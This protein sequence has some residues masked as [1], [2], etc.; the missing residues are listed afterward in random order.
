MVF[1]R[2]GID[3]FAH[4]RRAA[5]DQNVANQAASQRQDIP[6]V[7]GDYFHNG[8]EVLEEVETWH[9]HLR[10]CLRK[11]DPIT[12]VVLSLVE[13]HMLLTDPQTRISAK[14]LCDKLKKIKGDIET[15]KQIPVPQCVEHALQRT[16]EDWAEQ[17]IATATAEKSRDISLSRPSK[18]LYHGHLVPQGQSTQR[19]SSR[20]LVHSMQTSHRSKAAEHPSQSVLAAPRTFLAIAE[21]NPSGHLLSSSN[22]ADHLTGSLDPSPE[23]PQYNEPGLEMQTF[24]RTASSSTTPTMSSLKT[25]FPPTSTSSLATFRSKTDRLRAK[26]LGRPQKGDRD[27]QSHFENRDIVRIR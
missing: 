4:L 19:H 23:G 27:L 10:R 12:E 8:F 7:K 5:F 2:A 26:M 20:L 13:K 3:Q 25:W 16:E 18:A 15:I 11:N 1:G 6:L 17:V 21:S 24:R 22:R 14:D 9:D